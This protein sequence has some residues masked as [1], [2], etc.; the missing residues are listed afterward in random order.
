MGQLTPTGVGGWVRDEAGNIFSSSAPL[1]PWAGTGRRLMATRVPMD[2]DGG[3]GGN[4]ERPSS[5]NFEGAGGQPGVDLYFE[6]K[7][8]P[9][10]L[11]GVV[12]DVSFQGGPGSGYGR[13]VVVEST[14]PL[15]GKKVDVLYGHLAEG[16][17]KVRPGQ[18]IAAGQQIGTQGGTGRVV[19]QDGTIA[20][21]D[22]LA[23]AAAG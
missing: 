1:P 11:G 7:R 3:G 21:I 9:A 17:V 22:F 19:S 10:V 14:D 15:T 2:L 16:S 12:K 4:W 6:S 13:Y 8:F 5:L 18:R 20:S 23:P